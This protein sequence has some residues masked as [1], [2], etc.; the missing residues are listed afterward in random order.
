MVVT[1]QRRSSCCF[2][3]S[4]ALLRFHE[5]LCFLRA[6]PDGPKVLAEA[7]RILAGFEKRR[8]LRRHREALADSGVAGTVINYSFYWPTARWLAHRWPERLH[9]DWPAFEKSEGLV[10]YLPLIM[11]FTETVALDNFSAGP[12]KWIDLL[13]KPGE[14]DGS[15]LV[16]R[17][18]TEPGDAFTREKHYEDF[19]VPYRLQPG[20]D[21][22]NRTH[23]RLA[24]SRV[25]FQR[26][27]LRLERPDL[28]K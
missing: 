3:R 19:D 28:R 24:G 23:A 2:A 8:D 9:I 4:S 1:R 17:F 14:S 5:L 16:K 13:K 6:Y 15:F 27:A 20:P 26:R 11:P 25:V 12:R 21:T 18:E 10:E 7:E 22:P